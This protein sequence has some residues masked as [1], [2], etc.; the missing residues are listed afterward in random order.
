[1]DF[2]IISIGALPFHPLWGERTQVRTGHATTTLI[3]AGSRAIVV[4]P[5]LPGPALAARLAERANLRPEQVTD[6]FLTSFRPDVRRG[7][8][9]FEDAAWWISE[10]ERETVGVMMAERLRET[11]SGAQSAA[12]QA[13]RELRD[14]LEQDVAI[15]QRC[16]PAEDAF[17]ERVAIFPLPGVTPGLCGLLLEGERYTTLVCGDA[18]PTVEHLLAGQVL[19]NAADPRLAQES[20]AEAIEIADMLVPGRDNLAMNPTKR[21]F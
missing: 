7:V 16:K 9:I 20:F 5:G 1:M 11:A 2:R 6:V 19:P 10:R 18:V 12:A 4:D 14:V 15:L 13:D 8:T 21:L 3:R 17:A